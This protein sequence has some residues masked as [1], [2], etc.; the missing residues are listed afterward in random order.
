MTMR[1][2]GGK[3]ILITS[4]LCWASYCFQQYVAASSSPNFTRVKRSGS[5]QCAGG[6]GGGGWQRE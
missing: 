5:L 6:G 2:D 4:F 1:R 3:G